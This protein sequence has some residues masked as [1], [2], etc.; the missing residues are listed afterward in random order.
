ML[1]SNLLRLRSE[2]GRRPVVITGATGSARAEALLPTVARHASEI[3]LVVP[4]QSR[5]CDHAELE[6]AIPRDFEGR[7][8]HSA[9]D[10]LFPGPGVCTAGGPD[11]VIVV[12]GSI[13][14]LG[15]VLARIE[16]GRGP[17]EGRLQDF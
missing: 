7:V 11:D 3:Y 1:D 15:E 14:V 9:V 2:T 16:P 6:R 12:T 10:V 13:Y 8:F 4:K 17:G 5:A